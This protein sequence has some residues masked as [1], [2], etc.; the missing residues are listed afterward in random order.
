MFNV[1]KKTFAYGAHQVTIE[2]GE[3]ARQAGGAVVVTMEETVVLVTVVGAKNAKPGE[4]DAMMASF[5]GRAGAVDPSLYKVLQKPENRDPR[6][7]VIPANQADMPTVPAPGA[8][9]NH[10]LTPD[11]VDLKV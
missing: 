10:S 6:G 7:Y 1:A 2:T 9:I 5:F 8:W 11:R 3:V 4:E